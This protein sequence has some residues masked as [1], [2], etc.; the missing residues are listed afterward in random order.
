MTSSE[1]QLIAEAVGGN[2]T[3]LTALLEQCGPGVRRRI[4]RRIGRRHQSL[5]DVDDVMQVTYLEAFL[6]ISGFMPTGSGGF[7]A[8]LT[9]I[10]ENNL[11]DAVRALETMKRSPRRKQND[12]QP[13]DPCATPGDKSFVR[14]LAALDKSGTTPSGGAGVREAK[15]WIESGIQRLPA[16]YRTV[17]RRYDLE[18]RDATAVA[19]EMGR[20]VGAIYMLRARALDRLR[21]LLPSETSFF[22]RSA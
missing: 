13:D 12:P 5:L 8:W 1:G 15:E 17:L 21:T 6:Q 22:T 3:A 10:A 14:L 19:A 4:A 11:T 20:S 2:K 18:G 16:D 9:R 7:R